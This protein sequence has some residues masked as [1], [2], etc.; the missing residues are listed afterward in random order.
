MTNRRIFLLGL[1]AVGSRLLLPTPAIAAD[2][3]P[4]TPQIEEG[5]FYPRRFPED[6]DADLTRVDGH[7][8]TARGT[9]LAVSGRLIDRSGQPKA[10][11]RVEIWQCDSTGH[12]HHVGGRAEEEDA[13]FQGWGTCITD[14][15]GR[16]AFKTIRPVPYPGRTPHIHCTLVEGGKRT[17]TT[18]LFVEGDPGNAKDG[19]YR[20]LGRSASLVTMR[21]EDRGAGL[22]GAID[23]VA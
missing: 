22:A 6:S 16:Y 21:L 20:A 14:A 17:L 18:Q 7:T 3:H 1:G 19:I 15:D 2:F 23:I 12:Y 5:P 8:G 9:A 4:R 11:T 10:G 13:D